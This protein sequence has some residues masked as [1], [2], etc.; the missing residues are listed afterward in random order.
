MPTVPRTS[1]LYR[2]TSAMIENTPTLFVAMRCPASPS[3]MTYCPA[4][5]P[6]VDHAWSVSVE[7][8]VPEAA[9]E[10]VLRTPYGAH[11]IWLY[12]SP[13]GMQS[14][15]TPGHSGSTTEMACVS[16]V[17]SKLTMSGGCWENITETSYATSPDRS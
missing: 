1:T 16:C 8:Q 17:T 6:D 15:V 9:S 12:S 14:G 2:S 4:A 3:T 11:V 7:P 5:P 13:V 10:N